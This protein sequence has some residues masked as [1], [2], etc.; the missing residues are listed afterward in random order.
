MYN[1]EVMGPHSIKFNPIIEMFKE[2]TNPLKISSPIFGHVILTSPDAS[3][4]IVTFLKLMKFIKLPL[5][6]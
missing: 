6:A 1:T 4:V 2:L 5:V 3:V